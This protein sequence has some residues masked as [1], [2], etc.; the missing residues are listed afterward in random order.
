MG[1][2][3]NKNDGV[4]RFAVVLFLLII[5]IFS[6]I[7]AFRSF[8]G[9]ISKNNH[10][11]NDWDKNRNEITSKTLEKQYGDPILFKRL[12]NEVDES[13]IDRLILLEN[14]DRA[15]VGKPSVGGANVEEM[16]DV[17][18]V[19]W[20]WEFK[21]EVHG[22]CDQDIRVLERYS[23]SDFSF[24]SSR[25][26]GGSDVTI[27]TMPKEFSLKGG[28][29]KG[30]D[31]SNAPLPR[32][33]MVNDLRGIK[34]GQT[35][36]V[37]LKKFKLR[38][39][40]YDDDGNEFFRGGDEDEDEEQ[41]DEQEQQH[42]PRSMSRTSNSKKPSAKNDGLPLEVNSIDASDL[43]R[44]LRCSPESSVLNS[45]G[46]TRV[47][48][49]ALESDA[50]TRL[51]YLT[52]LNSLDLGSCVTILD[53]YRAIYDR[54]LTNDGKKELYILPFSLISHFY[55][56]TQ[57]TESDLNRIRS[58]GDLSTKSTTTNTNNANSASNEEDRQEQE[59]YAVLE[60]EN[61][62]VRDEEWLE[63]EES[64]KKKNPTDR[65][66]DLDVY[67]IKEG[68]NFKAL[69]IHGLEFYQANYPLLT[70]AWIL[71]RQYYKKKQVRQYIDCLFSEENN[72]KLSGVTHV[73]K[74]PIIQKLNYA[75]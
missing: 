63:R 65:D 35:S 1:T 40:Y 5:V 46:Y 9:E 73:E 58:E 71:T 6:G 15:Y 50:T 37:I 74:Y 2:N 64:E 31:C 34:L 54:L 28:S 20:P 69:Q 17:L 75:S 42:N 56:H 39:A 70:D 16:E 44:L 25:T 53:E 47:I 12:Q 68:L 38:I 21:N 36:L 55:Y 8:D 30:S 7:A 27:S 24:L 10:H 66:N 67:R 19:Q 32:G 57:I 52:G 43:A 61:N 18:L 60:S 4:F 14:K 62:L 26:L 45:L 23:Y 33:D 59:R 11:T 29:A 3:Y 22:N 49:P 48:L 51:L 41:E 72:L 13:E